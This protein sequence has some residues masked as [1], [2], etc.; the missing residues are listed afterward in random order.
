MSEIDF[1]GEICRIPEF[2]CVGS[3]RVPMLIVKM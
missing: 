2:F 1:K 3:R